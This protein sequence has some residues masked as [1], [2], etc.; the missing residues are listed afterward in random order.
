MS[1]QAFDSILENSFNGE[2]LKNHY[3]IQLV[4]SLQKIQLDL[5][6]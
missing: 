3:H 4:L 2:F 1:K 5:Q 6:I